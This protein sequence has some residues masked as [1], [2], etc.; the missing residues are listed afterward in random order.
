MQNRQHLNDIKS[1][2]IEFQLFNENVL[3]FGN[4]NRKHREKHKK[5]NNK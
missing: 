5:T 1:H 4:K 3:L 2:R